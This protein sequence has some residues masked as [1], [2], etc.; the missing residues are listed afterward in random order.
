[1]SVVANPLHPLFAAEVEDID[2]R[3]ALG[4]T[5]VREIERRMDE[6]SV[7][8]FRGQPLSQDQQIAFARNFGPLEGGFIKVN[9]RP[10][11]FKYAELADISNVSLDGKVAQ[12]DAREVVGNF[13][14]QLWHSDSSFQQP[15]ARYSMLSAVVVPPSGGDTEFCDMR[16]AY[17]ALPRDLQSELEG[18]RAEHYALNSRFLLGDTDYSEAQRNAMPPVNWPLVRTHAGSGRKFLFIGAHAG[19]VEGLPVAEGRMLLA[20]L[21]EHA[22]QR[23]FVYRHRWNVGDLVMWDNRCVLHRGRRYDISARRELRRATTLD[24]AVV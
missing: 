12:R 8:V 7:L 5:E 11:R 4:S 1:M 21:L 10:S 16:A 6:K 3:E 9:Q 13:A 2:L 23:E 15:A 24:D 18:L 14:N 17:D 22:T 20:E 19:H